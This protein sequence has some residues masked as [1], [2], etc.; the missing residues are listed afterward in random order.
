[1]SKKQPTVATSTCEAE[2]MAIYKAVQEIMWLSNFLQ[3]LKLIVIPQSIIHS[4][5]HAAITISENDSYHDR[6]KHIDIKYH[7]IREAI[8]N[9]IIKVQYIST[10][11][12]QADI[13]TKATGS[14]ILSK[15]RNLLMA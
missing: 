3:E 13:L 9:N 10:H 15:F 14:N 12:Q 8:K 5:N 1:M 4:D 7:F 2:Y 11:D 6:S